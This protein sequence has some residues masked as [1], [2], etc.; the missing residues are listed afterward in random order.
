M[1]G[2][3]CSGPLG[4]GGGAGS[5]GKR[6]GGEASWAHLGQIH[7]PEGGLIPAR[8]G[9]FSRLRSI[10]GDSRGVGRAAVEGFDWTAQPLWSPQQTDALGS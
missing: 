7:L 3:V 2:H 1:C 6:G 8:R 4:G 10:A 5:E 9:R